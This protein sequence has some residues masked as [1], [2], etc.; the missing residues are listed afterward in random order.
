MTGTP[1]APTD[2]RKQE[3]APMTGNQKSWDRLE[4]W[5]ESLAPGDEVDIGS[6]AATTGLDAQTCDVVFTALARADLFTR[7][8]DGTFVRR[9]LPGFGWPTPGTVER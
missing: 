8:S 1:V 5:L 9:R 3:K 4:R 2:R 7:R 6:A